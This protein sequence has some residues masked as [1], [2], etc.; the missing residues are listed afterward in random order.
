M[1]NLYTA[2]N[3][4]LSLLKYKKPFP[5]YFRENLPERYWIWYLSPSDW[6][7]FGENIRNIY[8]PVGVYRADMK[9]HRKE[10]R[11]VIDLLCWVQE[12]LFEKLSILN[13]TSKYIIVKIFISKLNHSS[14]PEGIK[15][16][17][18]KNTMAC[19]QARKSVYDNYYLNI[20]LELP[21]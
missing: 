10:R 15:D 21:F 17:I 20:L 6:N 9:N 4:K 18:H 8:E 7:I 13:C 11:E 14:L 5:Q 2:W 16:N 12:N 19:Y 3:H 1:I